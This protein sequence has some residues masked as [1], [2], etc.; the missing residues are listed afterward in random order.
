MGSLA[1]TVTFVS[2]SRARRPRS[3][4]ASTTLANN[5][6]TTAIG[7]A[8]SPHAIPI[9]IITNMTAASRVSLIPERKRMKPPR[10]TSPNARAVLCPMTTTIS[11]PAI[12]ISV[13][14][15]AVSRAGGSVLGSR[16]RHSR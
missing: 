13:C 5:V 14:A 6:A 2:R 15:C 8:P 11:A 3:K 10:P 4:I 16:R 12:A 9:P 1:W 7:T